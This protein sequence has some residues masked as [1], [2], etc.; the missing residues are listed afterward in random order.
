M[1]SEEIYG[2]GIVEVICPSSDS[3]EAIERDWNNLLVQAE[4]LA[5]ALWQFR[6]HSIVAD[7]EDLDDNNFSFLEG[8]LKELA[9]QTIRIIPEP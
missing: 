7:L 6:Q 4:N 1:K 3:E 9:G 5:Q 8:S 2:E